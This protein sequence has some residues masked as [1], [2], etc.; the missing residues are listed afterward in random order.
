MSASAHFFRMKQKAAAIAHPT[1]PMI[2][3]TRPGIMASATIS[4]RPPT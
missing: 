1:I 2:P 4:E 3:I